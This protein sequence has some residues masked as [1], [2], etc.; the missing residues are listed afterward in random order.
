MRIRILNT[1]KT[2]AAMRR[3]NDITAE[4]FTALNHSKMIKKFSWTK[5]K[6]IWVIMFYDDLVY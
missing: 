3:R 1:F 2:T 5:Y 6:Y 4:F